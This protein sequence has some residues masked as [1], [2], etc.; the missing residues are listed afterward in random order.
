MRIY[1]SA[2]LEGVA[3]VISPA[4]LYSGPA[5]EEACARM[6]LEVAAAVRGAQNAGAADIVINDAHESMTNLRLE[7]LPAGVRV[8]TGKPKP[9]GMMCAIDGSWDMAFF[10][11]YHSRQ[12]SS[13]ILSHSY[14]ARLIEQIFLNGVEVGELAFNAALAGYF[15]VPVALVTGDEDLAKEASAQLVGTR[16]ISVKRALSRQAADTMLPSEAQ[17]AIEA[18]AFTVVKDWQKGSGEVQTWCP[19]SPYR[20]LVEFH[21]PVMADMVAFMPEVQ[22]KRANQVE[23]VREDLPDLFRAFQAMLVLAGAMA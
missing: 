8:I 21:S 2:D 18:A 6:T 15:G 14:S 5:Y 19:E 9:L 11:G 7:M 16:F 12:G 13:G 3:G 22:R 17:K 4:Q 1:I 23:L 20:L 10:I